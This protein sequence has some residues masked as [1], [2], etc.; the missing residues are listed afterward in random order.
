MIPNQ[1]VLVLCTLKPLPNKAKQL[2][3][4]FGVS[5]LDTPCAPPLVWQRPRCPTAS[6]STPTTPL[7]LLTLNLTRQI[8]VFFGLQIHIFF[9][10]SVFVF[11]GLQVFVRLS[12]S[13]LH[14]PWADSLP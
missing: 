5:R 11:F 14:Y 1:S 12:G 13:L 6:I 10:F 7:L 2:S 4:L 9:G 8:L 3:S